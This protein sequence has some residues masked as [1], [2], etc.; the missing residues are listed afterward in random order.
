MSA[1][2]LHLLVVIGSAGLIVKLFALGEVSKYMSPSFDPLTALAGAVLAVMGGVDLIAGRRSIRSP[3]HP[4]ATMAVREVL[5]HAVVLAVIAVGL[6]VPPRALGSSALAGAPVSSVLL[7]FPPASVAPRP[8]GSAS[9]PAVA[10][11]DIPDLFAALRE[12]GEGAVGRE[13]TVSGLLVRDGS[14]EPGE[15]AVLRYA[16]VHCV[17]DA[18]PF[19]LLVSGDVPAPLLDRWVEVRGVVA[20][21]ARHGE[22]LVS[23]ASASVAAAAEPKNPYVTP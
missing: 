15:A 14:L 19:T 3:G 18:S 17:A 11:A 20:Q 2:L 9:S 22:R 6:I 8:A 1:R 10:I 23:V 5:G 16:I 7:T 4:P 21:Q 12:Q 13:V